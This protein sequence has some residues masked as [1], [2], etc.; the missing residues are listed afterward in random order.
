LSVTLLRW[1][2]DR[3]FLHATSSDSTGAGVGAENELL[4]ASIANAETIKDAGKGIEGAVLQRLSKSLMMAAS[5]IDASR[6]MHSYG[7]T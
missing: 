5:D 7:G 3:K 1:D 6:P 2:K 4:R